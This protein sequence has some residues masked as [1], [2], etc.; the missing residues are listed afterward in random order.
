MQRWRLAFAS[1]GATAPAAIFDRRP[2]D[3]L[4]GIGIILQNE[5]DLSRRQ[6]HRRRGSRP[7]SSPP[8]VAARARFRRSGRRPAGGRR[9][10]RQPADPLRSASTTATAALIAGYGR[11]GGAPLP[12]AIARSAGRAGNAV[13]RVGAGDRARGERIGTVY[14]EVDREPLSRRLTRYVVI[15][16]LMLMA[17]LV[18]AAL[19]LAQSALRRANRELEERADALAQANADARRV[20]I[21]ERAK[22]EDQLRQSQKMQALGQLTGGIAHDF[23]NLLT[24]IQG[25]ADMLRRPEL[26]EAKRMR[27]AEAIVQ[28]AGQCRGA[29]RNCSP[30][31]AASRSS[32]S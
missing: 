27:F 13:P 21:E 5:V 22:A 12:A 16:L 29:D 7:T 9:V 26:A 17:A 1:A 3:L 28:A 15:G 25:S 30:S 6:T 8:V 14:L 4:A 11:D 32:P 20:Q 10:P 24:V 23:N 18:V 19:G 31:P 2:A